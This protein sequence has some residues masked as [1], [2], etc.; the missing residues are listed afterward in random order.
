[1][2]RLTFLD[3]CSG[4]GGFRLGLEWAGHK[5]V[6]YCEYDKFAR[7]SYE[8]MYDTEGEWKAEDVTKLTPEE[9]PYA[10]AWC[11]GFP[12]FEAGTLVMTDRGYKCI[13]HIQ[14]G[15]RVLTH[16]N[17]FHPVVRP[18][19]HRAGE[20]YELDVF[21]VENL[22]VTGKHPF[23]VKDGDSA[24][25]KAVQEL[26]AGD[27]I[28]V[29]VNNKAELPEWDGITYERRGREYRL[30]GLDLGSRDFWWFVGCYMGDGWYRVT[31]RKNASDN[32]RVVIACNEEKL[33][34][35]KRH[36]DRMFRYSVAKERT[37][38]K[39]H[40][41]NKELTVFLMQFGKGAG[42]KRL[43]ETV[44][45]LPEDLLRA[46]LEGYFETDGCMVGKYHQASTISRELAYGIRDC[47]HKAYRM[48]CAVYRNKMPK[49]CV[50]EGRTVRQHD[51]YTVRFKEGRSERDGSFFMDGYV[52]C[53]FR[54]SRKVPFDGYVYNMEVEDDNSYTAG[55]L[56]AHNC[57]D[58]SIAGKQR[59]LRGK[60]SGI[61]YSIIDLIK[62]KE[63]GGKPTYLLVENV[64]NLLSVNAGFDF[65]AVL[66]EMDE[67][68][69]D[70]RW[71]VLN[72]KD[73]GVPQNRERVFLIA[74]LRSRGG[75]EILP[76][77]G[78]D[79]GALK[80]VIGGMQGYRVYDP[81]GVS[82]SIG[83][84][85]GGMGAK[86]GLYC[87]GDA[88][89][90]GR[91][92]VDQTLNHPKVTEVARCLIAQ[93]NGGLTNY[94][95]SG[96]LETDSAVQEARAVL[97]PDRMEKRQNGRRMKEAGEPMFTLTAQDQHGVY[98][99]EE[100][101]GD[102]EP[103]LPVRNGTKQGYDL[104]YPGDGVCL[105]Y[106][107]SE[108]RRGRVGKGCSQTLDTGCMMGTVTKCGK[109]RRLTPRECF[110]LQGFPDEL[111]ERAAAVNSETQLYKQAG[112]AVTATVAYAVA[113][114]LPES[115]ELLAQMEA[116]WEEFGDSVREAEWKGADGFVPGTAWEDFGDT[117]CGLSGDSG[118]GPDEDFDFLD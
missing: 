110:C 2:G 94:G 13:E 30:D 34:R 102:A 77:F 40:F 62:G 82:V 18:M 16:K 109:I 32:Y 54:G 11:F 39:V 24:K 115:R 23:L 48:P 1:M 42:G 105:S 98:L 38:Y 3:I 114:A 87:V 46:F 63:E 61:Y 78:E 52:W 15:D 92:F 37:A 21:G 26:E 51:F 91:I 111:Y 56:A 28:A 107:K 81:S 93:Y 118:T 74:V 112:N 88:E 84:N 80:E 29:P 7:A 67:A 101:S 96:I 79:G 53:R 117:A 14:A 116:V 10:D 9:I 89:P 76:V 27:L 43:T 35:L 104:A 50:I 49:T 33:E 25:W 6:G 108:S 64:K 5:C 22:R 75:R 99:T 8:A 71:Q 58:I 41:T 31:K 17:R 68:G 12:C 95:N 73:F 69:Y 44:F 55:G 45:N 4:I 72:S 103:A 86:T 60:R 65:A 97:T 85:G 70:V 47:V 59:G 57:Q 106:P 100:V 113:M 66:S 36:V 20:I 19:K 90:G 83:A